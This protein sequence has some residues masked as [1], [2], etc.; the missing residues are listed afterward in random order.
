[1]YKY[2][3]IIFHDSTHGKYRRPLGAVA[4][5][6]E[7][8]LSLYIKDVYV[9]N[10]FLRVFHNS[11]SAEY[12]MEYSDGWWS[13]R[14]IMPEEPGL[15]W[16]YFTIDIGQDRVFYGSSSRLHS[17]LG[18]IYSSN[19]AS[20][21]ITVHDAE[22]RTP[23]FFKKAIAYQIF[24]DRFRKSSADSGRSGVEYHKALGQ[25]AV[26]H[27]DF[28]DDVLYEPQEGELF[29][30][31]CD[32][33]GGDLKGIEQSLIDLASGGVTAIYLNP[34]FEADSNHRYNTSDYC[35]IDPILGSEEDFRSLCAAAEE[36]GIKIILDGVFSHTGD[37]S[38]YF[39]SR[40]SYD[41]VGAAQS[42]SSPY[43]SWYS[44]SS[45]PNE[46]KCWW[47]F[48]TLPEVD[49]HNSL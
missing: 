6:Q 14:V 41:S 30:A 34:I 7:V 25:K 19:P 46:Y 44:F 33:Y 17:G 5:G 15:V 42:K 13:T 37:D 18:S 22:F 43:Y 2:A 39:N 20:F 32:Y 9:D 1:M 29:Y 11:G 21:Q 26:Y 4:P 23:D 45:F 12:R 35:K 10:A 31:P 8:T 49:E 48:K 24:P 40:G 38:V 3:N 36:L 28:R 16:Y 47:G 27:S